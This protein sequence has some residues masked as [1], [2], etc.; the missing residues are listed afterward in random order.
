MDN[1][2]NFSAGVLNIIVGA[3]LFI[4]SVLIAVFAFAFLLLSFSLFFMAAIPAFLITAFLCVVTLV[5]TAANTATG[6]G[7]VLTSI[8]G[9]KLTKVFSIISIIVDAIVIPANMC[10]LAFGAFVMAD[11]PDFLSALIVAISALAISAATASLIVQCVSLVR[12]NKN[13]VCTE[14]SKQNAYEV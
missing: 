14:Q 11:E 3:V 8:N 7:S 5:A 6:I 4:D 9:G 12:A 2:L 10:A 13:P 1:K